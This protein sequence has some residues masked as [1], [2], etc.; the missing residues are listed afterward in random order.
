MIRRQ[1]IRW[2]VCLGTSWALK[3]GVDWY[4]GRDGNMALRL[5]EAGERAGDVEQSYPYGDG[6]VPV[7]FPSSLP[8]LANRTRIFLE[9]D[10]P[11]I[12]CVEFQSIR[13]LSPNRHNRNEREE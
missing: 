12:N 4:R 11:L 10:E 3:R 13:A 9:V 7:G 5:A 8:L 1:L 6:P 2:G